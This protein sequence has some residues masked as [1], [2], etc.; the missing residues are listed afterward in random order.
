VVPREYYRIYKQDGLELLCDTN[1][2]IMTVFLFSE[3]LDGFHQYKGK[4][5][6]GLGFSDGRE[7][8]TKKFGLPDCSG[9]GD[10]D[11]EGGGTRDI[12]DKFA[13]N[14]GAVNFTYRAQNTLK[15]ITLMAPS[16]DPGCRERD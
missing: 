11:K 8:V 13:T 15:Q 16:N 4:L 1:D 7:A 3:D 9:G 6:G 12:W 14:Y 2:R 5:P 10:R